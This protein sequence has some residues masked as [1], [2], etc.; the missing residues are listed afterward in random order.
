M[1][2]GRKVGI[3]AII[4]LVGGVAAYWLLQGD[5]D[6]PPVASVD[7][8]GRVERDGSNDNGRVSDRDPSMTGADPDAPPDSRD[9]EDSDDG[10]GATAGADRANA[11]LRALQE[12]AR[13]DPRPAG[14]ERSGDAG[15]EAPAAGIDTRDD[16]TDGAWTP[17]AD[18][19]VAMD[20]DPFSMDDEPGESLDAEDAAPAA[21]PAGTAAST[22]G[23]SSAAGPTTGEPSG[24]PPRGT[25]PAGDRASTASSAASA[26]A[27]DDQGGGDDAEAD[28]DADGVEAIEPYRLI[29]D[30]DR[31]RPR[32][33]DG[34][35]DGDDG[36]ERVGRAAGGGTYTVVEGDSLW[37]IAGKT[38]GAGWRWRAIAEA[39]PGVDETTVL[40]PGMTLRIPQREEE[41]EADDADEDGDGESTANVGRIPEP[42]RVAEPSGRDPLGLGL[43][44]NAR[45]V[46]VREDESLWVIAAREYGDGTKWRVIYLANRDRMDSPEDL[47]PGDKL[48]V[49]PLPEDE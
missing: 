3:L 9:D 28:A 13:S 16:T 20:R 37:D 39:N 43:D 24:A 49:P 22:D 11:V 35:A 17:G 40:R 26:G 34:R 38:L 41:E 2:T 30:T 1:S 18:D 44:D 21:T 45:E 6:N 29:Q 48:R 46:T 33:G 23:L 15:A 4:I 27:V 10:A 19:A 5:P 42:S 25:P 7:R 47:H 32:V 12:T 36:G 8:D 31:P 14:A